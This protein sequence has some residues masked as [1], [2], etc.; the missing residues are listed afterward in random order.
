M[1]YISQ[2]IR[3]SSLLAVSAM[4]ILS[5][6]NKDLQQFTEPVTPVTGSSLGET[7][8]ANADDSLYVALVKRAGLLTTINNTA[9]TFTMFVPGNNAMRIF[10]N[11]ASGGAIPVAA[12]DAIHSGFISTT[13]P[14]ATA[15]A[16]VSYN[17]LPQLVKAIDIPA[18]FPNLQ[19]PTIF[20]PAPTLSALLRLTTFPSTANGAWV[21]NVPLVDVDIVAS[22]GIIHRTA[23]L[24]TP[25]QRYLWNRI[26]TDAGLTYLKNAILRADSA[27]VTPTAPGTLQSA[28]LNIG[29]NLT[30][31]APTDAAFQATIT[32]VVTQVLIGLGLDPVTA[33]A[34]A[35]IIA[36]DPNVFS[37]PNLYPYLTAQTVQ[38]IVVYH[39]LGKRA[40][41][42]NFPTTV[43]LF[44]TLLNGAIP[45]HPGIGLEAIFGVPFVATATVKGLYNN[46]AAN[47]IINASPL[48]PDP[49]G[50]SDQHYLNGTI[51]K[52]DQV[53]LPLPF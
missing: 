32:G 4:L 40:F 44:K 14:V 24:V 41:T 17:I 51:H 16:I 10:V 20:N 7:L 8:V 34:Q 29:A 12:P 9:A 47:V 1:K 48:T 13:I 21:N 19:Y 25:P 33:A 39:I 53:L 23:F 37:N 52:I 28:L 3:S 50:T 36:A 46:T 18:T 38:G 30:V 26:N 11:A 27:S 22:N 2:I 49:F 42:N 35:A 15:N 5:A 6:C 43:T 31:F 45:L